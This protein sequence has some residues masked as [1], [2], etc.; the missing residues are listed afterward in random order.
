MFE[1][2]MEVE[3]NSIE[4]QI[5]GAEAGG[6]VVVLEAR[7]ARSLFIAAREA[8]EIDELRK[9]ADDAEE[10]KDEAEDE[11]RDETKRADDAEKE[12]E[13]LKEENNALQMRIDELESEA[14]KAARVV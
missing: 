12:V 14:A 9:R 10:K 6:G 2:L 8:S 11:L 7:S 1:R 5:E 4:K 13:T 3:M